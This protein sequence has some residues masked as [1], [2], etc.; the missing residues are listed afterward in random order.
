MRITDSL[1][2]DPDA[3]KDWRQEEKGTTEDEMAGWHHWLNGHE[4]EQAPGFSDGQGSLVTESYTT[5]WLNWTELMVFPIVMCWCESW[6]IKKAEHQRID[7]FKSWS[8]RRLES[9]LDCKEI[10]P[11]NPKEV[12]PEYPLERLMLK[13]KLQYFGHVMWRAN[14]LKNT[15]ILG[16]VEGRRR[17]G[18]QRMRW[19]DGI[20]NLMDMS[21]NK[22]WEIV[23][24]R[25]ACVLQS[26]GPQRVE[27]DWVTEQQQL[28][29]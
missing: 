17:R 5:E 16:K 18:W 21:L 8:W 20:T 12:N 29:T 15:L 22:L 24:D 25:E 27:H 10:K 23:K 28:Q 9:P 4:F 11:V 2:K 14:S 3:G 19:L 7:A 1:E 26:M 6:A 13:L